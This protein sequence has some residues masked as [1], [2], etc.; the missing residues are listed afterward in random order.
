MRLA[1]ETIFIT[2]FTVQG[3]LLYNSLISKV[4]TFP[5]VL[6]YLSCWLWFLG[7]LK[8][9]SLLTAVCS[10]QITSVLSKPNMFLIILN[11]QK[12]NKKC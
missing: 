1:D 12:S 8:Y 7:S 4:H 5:L 6:P 9:S 2:D 10:S 3:Y 11:L